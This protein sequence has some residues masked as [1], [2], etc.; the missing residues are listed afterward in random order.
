MQSSLEYSRLDFSCV[1]AGQVQ[2]ERK[3]SWTGLK[4]GEGSIPCEPRI[5]E[6][7][8]CCVKNG[9]MD[10]VQGT[11]LHRFGFLLAMSVIVIVPQ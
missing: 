4:R 11:V 3:E 2:R 7:P 5:I 6:R 1:D 8:S 9:R 10:R